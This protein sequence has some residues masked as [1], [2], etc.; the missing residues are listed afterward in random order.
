MST[1]Y[2][3][4]LVADSK[5]ASPGGAQ[6]AKASGGMPS[7]DSFAKPGG[8]TEIPASKGPNRFP[9]DIAGKTG[10]NNEGA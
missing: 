9:S 2:P 8:A 10:F 3:E 4:T 7:P 6:E 5:F 1:A